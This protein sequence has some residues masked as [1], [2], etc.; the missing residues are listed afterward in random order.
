MSGD[1]VVFQTKYAASSWGSWV[2]LNSSSTS[3]ASDI[4]V[5]PLDDTRL[6]AFGLGANKEIYESAYVSPAWSGWTSFTPA[7]TFLLGTA[8]SAPSDGRLWVFAIGVDAGLWA[9]YLNAGTGWSDWNDLGGNCTSSPDSTS[10]PTRTWAVLRG[11]DDQLYMKRT[12]NNDQ[13]GLERIHLAPDD[14]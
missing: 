3:I 4:D 2:A 14:G 11:G 1:G 10:R 6:Q 8:A 13:I 9:R 12:D 7:L 5:A